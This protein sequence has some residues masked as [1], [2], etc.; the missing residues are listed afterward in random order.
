[1]SRQLTIM[2]ASLPVGATQ[3]VRA[4]ER[5]GG[6]E[7]QAQAQRQ[8]QCLPNREILCLTRAA[9][10]QNRL[11]RPGK[12]RKERKGEKGKGRRAEIKRC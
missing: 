4:E 1:M 6:E 3:G 8:R 5:H 2:A 12:E 11:G 7:T 9:S 10:L